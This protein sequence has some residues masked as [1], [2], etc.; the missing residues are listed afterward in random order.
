MEQIKTK[1]I[2]S[3]FDKRFLNDVLDIKK[4]SRNIKETE[5]K[6]CLALNISS[7]NE[8]IEDDELIK[9]KR[10][11]GANV[12][13]KEKVLKNA[14]IRLAYELSKKQ[15]CGEYNDKAFKSSLILL[16]RLSHTHVGTLIPN[17]EMTLNESGVKLIVLPYLRESKLRGFTKYLANENCYLIAV[18]DCGKSLDRFYFALFHEISHILLADNKSMKLT[19]NDSTDLEEARVD[20]FA[21]NLLIDQN[22]YERFIAKQ[23]FNLA[24]ILFFA[25]LCDI[26]PSLVIARLQKDG[27]IPYTYFNEYKKKTYW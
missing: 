20:K 11:G 2:I 25:K 21:A 19:Y 17:L 14:W 26:D 9:C 22:L 16:K 10:L 24:S 4:E 18:N 1:E 15:K 13:Y 3:Y 5:K 27:Y 6:I 12:S 23:S 7:L 8:L